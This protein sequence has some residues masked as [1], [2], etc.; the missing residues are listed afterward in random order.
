[1]KNCLKKL[2]KSKYDED[3]QF[4]KLFD[5]DVN[6]LDEEKKSI[7]I[8]AIFVEKRDDIDRSTLYSF[9]GAFQLLPADVGKI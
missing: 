4:V 2:K 9:D 7:P 6:F 8:K 5:N 3:E 1:M